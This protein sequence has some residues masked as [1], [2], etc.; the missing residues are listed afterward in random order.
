MLEKAQKYEWNFGGSQ[1][2]TMSFSHLGCLIAN[3][4]HLIAN[5][6]YRW[7]HIVS[8]CGRSCLS[9]VSNR[10]SARN[11][12]TILCM[13]MWKVWNA[14]ITR[15]VVLVHEVQQNLWIFWESLC[16]QWCY[17]TWA[18]ALLHH[19]HACARLLKLDEL[20]LSQSALFLSDFARLQFQGAARWWI[21]HSPQMP[22]ASPSKTTSLHIYRVLHETR[23][24]I[25]GFGW[26][27][28]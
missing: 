11:I 2:F 13:T 21:C 14:H 1:T 7:C 23:V 24:G 4:K 10:D 26:V 8:W 28:S 20:F 22:E 15:S 5:I 9:I 19:S 18:T 3:I 12:L 17:L 6:K 27:V 25:T 16:Y